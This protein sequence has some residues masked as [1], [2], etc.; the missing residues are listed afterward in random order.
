MT[1]KNPILVANALLESGPHT[2]LVGRAADNLA[3]DLGFDVVSNE[4]FT[5]AFRLAHW[6]KQPAFPEMGTVGAVVLDAH[7]R[8]AAGGLT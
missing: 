7:G 6:K 4:F 8:L 5:T 1:T 2:M 3:K